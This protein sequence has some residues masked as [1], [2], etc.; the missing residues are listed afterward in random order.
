[1]VTARL[2]Q[3]A[4][5]RIASDSNDED[6]IKPT[7]TDIARSSEEASTS[8]HSAQGLVLSTQKRVN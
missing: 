6:E 5:V 8:K 4:L 2:C 7:K 3:A 1:M